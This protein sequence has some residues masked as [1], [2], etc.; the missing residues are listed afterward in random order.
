M[1]TSK[2]SLSAI[3]TLSGGGDD[4]KLSEEQL[5][6]FG[7]IAGSNDTKDIAKYLM[8]IGLKGAEQ[9][10]TDHPDISSKEGILNAQSDWKVSALS[11]M[12][13]RARGLNLKTPTQIKANQEALL[14]SLDPRYRDAIRHP[15]FN[16]IHGNWWDS[17]NRVLSDQYAAESV[18]TPTTSPLVAA[19]TK[20]P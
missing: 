6:K 15:A 12:L 11:K 10:Y 9:L 3:K 17:F 18:P 4:K 8:K 2:R 5:I 14:G 19:L 7:R 20:K 13:M 16:Q 1:A